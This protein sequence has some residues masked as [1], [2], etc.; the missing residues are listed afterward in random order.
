MFDRDRGSAS[1]SE[2]F[3]GLLVVALLVFLLW[4]FLL[5]LREPEVA[6]FGAPS[7]VTV[8][9]EEDNLQKAL[10]NVVVTP[11][12]QPTPTPTPRPR[13]TATPTPVI[14]TVQPGDV[15]SAIADRFGVSVEEIVAANEIADP[16]VLAVGQELEI[17]IADE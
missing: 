7:T 14:Y 10:E 9:A 13:A 6:T 8:E 3:V 5:R 4:Y 17:P 1:G 16:D 11:T 15:L 2:F 12:A